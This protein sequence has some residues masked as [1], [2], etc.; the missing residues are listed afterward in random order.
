MTE[1]SNQ[2]TAA[3]G[4]AAS[5]QNAPT[6][7]PTPTYVSPLMGGRVVS[8]IGGRFSTPTAPPALDIPM[9]GELPAGALDTT[10]AATPIPDMPTSRAWQG[11]GPTAGR[12]DS[13]DNNLRAGS[14]N[15]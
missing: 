9:P 12:H 6:D 2:I 15:I 3:H 10:T 8:P 11:T 5:L 13:A 4:G 1:P 7:C 14:L